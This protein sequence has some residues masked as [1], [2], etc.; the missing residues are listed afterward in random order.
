[1]TGDESLDYKEAL[2]KLPNATHIVEE[3]GNH[4]FE[5]IERHFKLIKNF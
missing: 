5:N 2:K 1:Q 3:G 4:S